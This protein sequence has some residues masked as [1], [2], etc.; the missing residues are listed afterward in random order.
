MSVFRFISRSKK[1]IVMAAML[2]PLGS[3]VLAAP[4]ANDITSAIDK[5]KI[6]SSN[7][8]V[9]AAVNGAEVYISTY[10]NAKANDN[11][12]KI[13]AVLIAKTVMDL[14]PADITRV[15]VYFYNALR[16]S[17]RKVVSVSAG[18]VK[19]FGA[20]QLSQEQLL[21]SISLK[22]EEV[23]DPAAKLS[24]YLQQRE[25]ARSRKRIDTAMRG[26]TMV[27][28]ADAESDMSETDLRYEAIKIAAKAL[29]SANGQAAKVEVDF[30]DPV[31]PGQVK[32]IVLTSSQVN[33]LNSSLQASL[34][35][36]QI[37]SVGQAVDIKTL[38]TTDG[39]LKEERDKLLGRLQ[40]L[41]KQGV[42][43]GPFVKQFIE[44]EKLAAQGNDEQADAAVKRLS[45]AIDE[46]EARTKGA[47]AP[48]PQVAVASGKTYKAPKRLV[49]P[50]NRW[51]DGKGIMDQDEILTNPDLFI[52]R[53]EA[54]YNGTAEKDKNFL[55]A[56]SYVYYTLAENNRISDAQRFA[57]RYWDI[58][59][60]NGWTE[61]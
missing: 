12:C 39:A 43:V 21:T 34:G 49:R 32:Q 54:M 55:K 2:L 10:R 22:D 27:V 4:T 8:R 59:N 57:G 11:D 14:S 18:D 1:P 41:D 26:D 31:A 58:L 20:G 28:T 3:Q 30:N 19:A 60:K 29:E 48:K 38:T 23:N 56:L 33:S 61:Q 40:A 52:Q 24:A 7:T 15:T 36:V 45:S 47:R 17:S 5:A 13:E 53:R 46:Q 42:G 25:T 9:A 35:A 16:R 44:L 51:G 50:G 37:A 6:L